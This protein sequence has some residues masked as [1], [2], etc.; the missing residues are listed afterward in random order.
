M[1]I[2]KI[3]IPALVV[4]IGWL[5]WSEF[6][7]AL[8]NDGLRQNAV[9]DRRSIEALLAY[10]RVASRCDLKPEQVARALNADT[11]PS[12]AESTTSVRVLAFTATFSDQGPKQLEIV[13]AGKVPLC[14]Q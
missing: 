10:A 2:Q 5:A 11:Y 7:L 14:S 3:A 12:R 9:A 1:S 13:D 8:E 6:N 4:A